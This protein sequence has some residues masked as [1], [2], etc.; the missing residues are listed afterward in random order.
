MKFL[1]NDQKKSNS[2]SNQKENKPSDF[3]VKLKSRADSL[4]SIFKFSDA[5]DLLNNG[6]KKDTTVKAYKD[7]I[8]K[9]KDVKD[10]SQ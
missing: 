6:E 8:K 3:A 9:L 4:V 2:N 10:I 1:S 7:F 5:Y